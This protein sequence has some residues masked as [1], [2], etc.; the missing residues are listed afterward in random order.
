MEGFTGDA[1]E[2]AILKIIENSTDAELLQIF[3]LGDEDAP[4]LRDL[5][6]EFDGSEKT[7]LREL[8][9]R[10][11]A[12]FPVDAPQQ[13]T[14]GL[15]IDRPEVRA[16]LADAFRQ[17]HAQTPGQAPVVREC[18][19]VFVEPKAGG[20]LDVAM[21]CAVGTSAEVGRIA[22]RAVKGRETTH[23]VVGS[24]HTHPRTRPPTSNP[25]PAGTYPVP[26]REAPSGADFA[27]FAPDPARGREHYVVGP[28]VTYL[29]ARGGRFQLLGN[30]AD[31]LG[32][33]RFPP[34][35]GQIS[36]L[37]LG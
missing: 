37:E 36:T 31:L 21:E 19:G 26:A 27:S 5:E 6:A 11:R 29:I 25:M 24:F 13:A 12:R 1:E 30:T 16:A 32:V 9:A 22:R 2:R 7:Y 33:E 34:E 8:L 14:E 35:P 17:T 18:G 23:R 15:L 4:R 3:G 28:Y 20:S 10:L